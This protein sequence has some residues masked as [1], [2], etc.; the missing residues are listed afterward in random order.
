MF[1]QKNFKF[2]N[3]RFYLLPWLFGDFVQTLMIFSTIFVILHVAIFNDDL[4]GFPAGS[5]IFCTIIWLGNFNFIFKAFKAYTNGWLFFFIFSYSNLLMALCCFIIPK[6]SSWSK[7]IKSKTFATKS[8]YYK[9]DTSR[10]HC[11]IILVDFI[12]NFLNLWIFLFYFLY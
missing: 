3:N 1:Y 2:Q 10:F 8:Y 9:N 6:N 12:I 4:T 5:L 11:I 7:C